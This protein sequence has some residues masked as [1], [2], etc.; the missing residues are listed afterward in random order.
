M[1][2]LQCTLEEGHPLDRRVFRTQMSLDNLEEM[3]L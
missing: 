1:P 3:Y 2:P